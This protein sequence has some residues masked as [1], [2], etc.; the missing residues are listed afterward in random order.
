MP[1]PRWQEGCGLCG[2]TKQH[3]GLLTTEF[4]PWP[5]DQSEVWTPPP[6]PRDPP[7][8]HFKLLVNLRTVR[9][10]SITQ[11]MYGEHAVCAQVTGYDFVGCFYPQ[12][13]PLG[14]SW[15]KKWAMALLFGVE[16]LGPSWINW[17]FE[18]FHGGEMRAL[19]IK[20]LSFLSKMLG[21]IL[22]DR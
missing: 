2:G 20:R 16:M 7:S 3:R 19:P 10:E 9:S 21:I 8:S 15:P 17:S 14:Y 11:L 5:Q 22:Q 1:C 6:T 4:V 18:S 12:L 13:L